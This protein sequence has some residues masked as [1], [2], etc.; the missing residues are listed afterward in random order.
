MKWLRELQYCAFGI[1]RLFP[2]QI[3]LQFVPYCTQSG[4]CPPP[5]YSVGLEEE[6]QYLLQIN[7]RPG[8][9]RWMLKYVLLPASG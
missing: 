8:T 2:S 5:A 7:A 6:L 4:C 3:N 1:T 9:N